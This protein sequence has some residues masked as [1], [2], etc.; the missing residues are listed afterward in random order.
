[1]TEDVP[2]GE[3]VTFPPPL[4]ADE[5][6]LLARSERNGAAP[7]AARLQIAAAPKSDEARSEPH[8]T[9]Q[10][11]DL[12]VAGAEPPIPPDIGGLFYR[13]RRHLLSGEDDSGKSWLLLAVAADEVRAGR[14]VAWIDADAMGSS[15]VLER[16]RSLGLDD[17][18]ISRL[19]AYV[20]PAEPVD[21]E[22]RDKLLA[23]IRGHDVR[24]V[25]IDAINGALSLHGYSVN[26]TEEVD[27]FF[28]RV[29][30]PFQGEGAAVV[31]PDHLVKNKEQR[32]RYS[33]GSQRKATGVDLHL[34]LTPI[35]PFGRGQRG[36]S[37][38]TV[39]RDRVGFLKQAPPGYLVLDSDPD[40]GRCSWRIESDQS[41]TDEG[42]FRPTNLM[43]KVSRY[44]ELREEPQSRSQ[45]VEDVKGKAT[46]IRAAID[47]LIAE[48]YA[49][50][51]D[52]ERG[53]R[54]VKLEQVFREVD[55]WNES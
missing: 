43:E 3:G 47:R 40:T 36:R 45:I 28:A 41:V 52:G 48:G 18:A 39:H 16:L 21:D 49:V 37:K 5:E 6:E 23:F 22:H 19:F 24:L 17:E 55:E 25:V 29:V 32:G 8:T 2:F 42:V 15:M 54:L 30:D 1:M 26:S 50:D 53:A 12:V 10:I 9:W 7:D 20:A 44:L 13:G 4:T 11:Q 31:M 35:E 14:G 38:M 27:A 51:F 34:G 33:I 46:G